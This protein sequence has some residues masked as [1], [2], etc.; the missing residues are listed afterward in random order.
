MERSGRTESRS[1]RR[2][3]LGRRGAP[4]DRVLREALRPAGLQLGRTSAEG[5]RFIV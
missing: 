1:V 4:G 3:S 2:Q 5:S